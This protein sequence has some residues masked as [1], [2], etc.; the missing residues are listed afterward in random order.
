MTRLV[1]LSVLAALALTAAA[2]DSGGDVL[3][4]G[5]QLYVS[6]Q[7][8]DTILLESNLDLPCGPRIATEQQNLNGRFQITVL[9]TDAPSGT[10]DTVAPVRRTI[11]IETG[12]A[13]VLPVDIQFG[14]LVDEYR[15]SAGTAGGTAARLDSVRVSVTIPGP[16]PR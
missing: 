7:S 5:G 1:R 2:C 10:C 15:Y 16:R 9:G 11:T 12:G 3:P 4:L 6:L 8:R 14:G 13:T